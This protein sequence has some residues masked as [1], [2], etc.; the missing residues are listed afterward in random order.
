LIR[1][2]K[3]LDK[4]KYSQTQREQ[5]QAAILAAFAELRAERG[6]ALEQERVLREA[7]G[8]LIW[9]MDEVTNSNSWLSAWT[10]LATHGNDYQ[11]DT[12]KEEY[13][14]LKNIVD[15]VD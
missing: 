1:L 2:V 3:T 10:F 13:Q 7:A 14:E 12:W 4:K 5:D 9:K 15:I 6:A 8:A 11:G